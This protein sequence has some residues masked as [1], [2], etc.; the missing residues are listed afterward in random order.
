[1]NRV[2]HVLDGALL[3]S[4]VL[5]ASVFFIFWVALSGTGPVSP[6]FGIRRGVGGDGDQSK[7]A[8]SG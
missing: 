4:T 8:S 2:N 3:R 6:L 5:R 7:A 1:M